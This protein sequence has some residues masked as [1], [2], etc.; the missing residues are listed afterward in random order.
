ML[1]S[2]RKDWKSVAII[3]FNIYFL[4]PSENTEFEKSVGRFNLSIDFVQLDAKGKPDTKAGDLLDW[5][6]V[7][8][9]HIFFPFSKKVANYE[10]Q[11]TSVFICDCECVKAD[12]ERWGA[13]N[14]EAS[15]A[16]IK[17]K[18]T[19]TPWKKKQRTLI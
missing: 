19:L 15:G 17:G 14:L 5:N 7:L 2:R 10:Q 16:L 12:I 6:K 4:F 1:Q 3:L 18:S 9:R 8:L 11:E 13:E